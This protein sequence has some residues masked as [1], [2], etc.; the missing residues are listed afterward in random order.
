MHNAATKAEN[1]LFIFTGLICCYL[2]LLGYGPVRA[3]L[4]MDITPAE[5]RAGYALN[6]H[7][8]DTKVHHR[9]CM[10]QITE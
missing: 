9:L 3:G 6:V 7:L 4:A 10:I 8:S 5:V 1:I 2:N